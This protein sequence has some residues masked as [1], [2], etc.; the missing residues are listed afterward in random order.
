VDFDLFRLGYQSP[1]SVIV[2]AFIFFGDDVIAQLDALVA[3][4][5]RRP[6]NKLADLT[7]RLS[8]EAAG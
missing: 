6:C 3:D 7:L 1:R 8:A 4:V 5:N 2:F